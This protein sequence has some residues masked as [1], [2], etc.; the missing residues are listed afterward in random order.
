MN[1]PRDVALVLRQP[2]IPRSRILPRCAPSTGIVYR[3]VHTERARM[4]SING[5]WKQRWTFPHTFKWYTSKTSVPLLLG[6]QTSL[7]PKWWQHELWGNARPLGQ[8]NRQQ[9]WGVTLIVENQDMKDISEPNKRT[10]R[11]TVQL[12]EALY[13]LTYC[14]FWDL[15]HKREPSLDACPWTTTTGTGTFPWAENI[16]LWSSKFNVQDDAFR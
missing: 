2:S 13:F 5:R 15:I 16:S 1:S 7:K 4:S 11:S 8:P 3:L 12:V 9:L 6:W 14:L 10:T